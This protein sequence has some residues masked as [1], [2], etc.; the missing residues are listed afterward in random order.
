MTCLRNNQCQEHYVTNGIVYCHVF[1]FITT[2]ANISI[3]FPCFVA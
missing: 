1:V 2:T 3:V